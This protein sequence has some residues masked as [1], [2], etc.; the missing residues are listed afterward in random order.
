M[1]V[2]TH[3]PYILAYRNTPEEK[4]VP[5]IMVSR[6]MSLHDEGSVHDNVHYNIHYN[7]H[8]NEPTR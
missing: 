4:V 7:V 3:A 5:H 6:E 2:R 1:T 8:Y